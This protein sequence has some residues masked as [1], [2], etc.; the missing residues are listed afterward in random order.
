MLPGRKTSQEEQQAGVSRYA[1]QVGLQ[2]PYAVSKKSCKDAKLFFTK[3][4]VY[5]ILYIYKQSHSLTIWREGYNE[6]RQT[7]RQT[8]IDRKNLNTQGQQKH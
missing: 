6:G 2:V 3:W 5:F 7:D 4:S 8:E 1:G